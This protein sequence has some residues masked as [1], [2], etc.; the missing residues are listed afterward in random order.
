[1]LFEKRHRRHLLLTER[2]NYNLIVG[3]SLLAKKLWRKLKKH[4]FHILFTFHNNTSNAAEYNQAFSRNRGGPME[5][6]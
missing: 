4:E 1:M 2:D 5:H 6:F 3:P